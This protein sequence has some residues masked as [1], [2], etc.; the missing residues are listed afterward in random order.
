M[1]IKPRLIRK[2]RKFLYTM[3][4]KDVK[5]YPIDHH[6]DIVFVKKDRGYGIS[7]MWNGS[8]ISACSINKYEAWK[9]MMAAMDIATCEFFNKNFNREMFKE[10]GPVH[11]EGYEK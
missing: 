10:H 5:E 7:C 11:M 8:R 1:A 4:A 2:M 3:G 6:E 9:G